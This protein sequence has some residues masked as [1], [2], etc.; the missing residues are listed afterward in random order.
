MKSS[1][2][3]P[4]GTPTLVVVPTWL[5][6][7]INQNNLDLSVL[8]DC[9]KLST[10]LSPQDIAIYLMVNDLPFLGMKNGH[11]SGEMATEIKSSFNQYDFSHF[12]DKLPSNAAN[13]VAEYQ[14]YYGGPDKVTKLMVG[15][16]EDEGELDYI[17]RQY[18]EDTLLL[19]A[20]HDTP[21]ANGDRLER[22]IATLTKHLS[23]HISMES[24][25][26]LP[27]FRLYLNIL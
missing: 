1:L 4:P 17:V 7:C 8:F 22:L 5:N 11:L 6:A 9:E 27:I 19:I 16:L 18:G 10:I 14:M 25:A 26:K 15:P 23:S 3:K 13:R 20:T 2:G 24:L 21:S 12:Y